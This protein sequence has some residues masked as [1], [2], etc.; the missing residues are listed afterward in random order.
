MVYGSP[1]ATVVTVPSTVGSIN[2]AYAPPYASSPSGSKMV[3]IA[4]RTA[5]LAITVI[6]FISTLAGADL[7]V[8]TI[9][10][11]YITWLLFSVNA[12]HTPHS[13]PPAPALYSPPAVLSPLS[14]SH[15]V[16]Y[17]AAPP[18]PPAVIV[19]PPPVASPPPVIIVSPP[20]APPPAVIIPSPPPLP[21]LPRFGMPSTHRRHFADNSQPAAPIVHPYVPPPLPA[22]SPLAPTV[23]PYIPPP[24][25][26]LSSV[27]QPSAPALPVRPPAINPA[28]EPPRASFAGSHHASWNTATH[29]HFEN[30]NHR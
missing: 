16:S 13:L 14:A 12:N 28:V 22:L 2:G 25:P 4:L 27:P 8:P 3:L 19:A 17:I 10:F 21:S 11:A 6:C 7:M 26:R 15:S 5:S 29:R 23:R 1:V 18:P 24:P 30:H 9:I 20:V